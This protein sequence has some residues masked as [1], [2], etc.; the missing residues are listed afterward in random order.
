MDGTAF[1]AAIAVGSD[2]ALRAFERSELIPALTGGDP[3]PRAVLRVA[4]DSEAAARDTFD[5]WADDEA[6]GRVRAAFERVAEQE[7][8]HYARLTEFLDAH[9]EPSAP[10]PLHSSLRGRDGTIER[11]ATGMIGRVMVSHRVHETLIEFFE[12]HDERE[13][14]DCLRDLRDETIAVRK[15]GKDLLDGCCTS[16]NDWHR[17]RAAAEYT[18]SV[19]GDA[20]IDRRAE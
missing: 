2:Q 15:A 19:A 13:I 11:V 7:R 20:L 5:R 1:S 10:G 4:A 14:A 18:V 3:Q 12:R 17:A 9:E 8:D 16:E 6:N